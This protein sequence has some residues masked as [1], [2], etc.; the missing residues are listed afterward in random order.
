MCQLCKRT[1]TKT[2]KNTLVRV[3]GSALKSSEMAVLCQLS[4]MVRGGLIHFTGD[5]GV[6]E[7]GAAFNHQRQGR[8][9]YLDRNQVSKFQHILS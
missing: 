7:A 1:L 9:V 6:A 2:L 4:M 5:K 8:H 3:V